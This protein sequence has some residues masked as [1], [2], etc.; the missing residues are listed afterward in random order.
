MTTLSRVLGLVRDVVLARFFGAAAGTDAFFIAFKIPNFLRRLFAEGAY[1]PLEAQGE[2]SEHVCAFARTLDKEGI[3]VIVPRLVV[4]L[5]GGK[6]EPPMR[7]EIW[8]DT[9]LTL[10]QEWAGRTFRNLFTGEEYSPK[11]KGKDLGIPLS[12]A[13]RNF[14]V[15]LLERE[16]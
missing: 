1:L 11:R 16:E 15:A 12:R 8:K 13:F 2:K 5:T 9:W 10:P 4:G 7:E 6:E 14:P 3:I